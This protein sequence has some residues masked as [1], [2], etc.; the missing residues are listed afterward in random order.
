MTAPA[1]G[2]RQGT[3]MFFPLESVPYSKRDKILIVIPANTGE[4]G[5]GSVIHQL[6]PASDTNQ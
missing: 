6:G 2:R 1:A 5:I 4:R 3:R